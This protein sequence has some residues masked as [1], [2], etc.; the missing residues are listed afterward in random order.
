MYDRILERQSKADYWPA[1]GT[2]KTIG[3][4]DPDFGP[5]YVEGKPVRKMIYVPGK[6]ANVVV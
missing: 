3:P 2:V 1:D 4:N 5:M 6:L